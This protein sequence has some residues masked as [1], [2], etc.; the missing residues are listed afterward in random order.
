[1]FKKAICGAALALCSVSA[2]AETTTRWF[3]YTGM[4]EYFGGMSVWYPDVTLKG[5]FSGEDLNGNNI[6]EQD[7][8]T[9]LELEGVNFANPRCGGYD[10]WI[11]RFSFSG[12]NNLDFY[13][14]YSARS[15]HESVHVGSK[16]GYTR[17]FDHEP[18]VHYYGFTLGTTFSITAVPEPSS[19]LMLGA[20][21]V[22]IGA[23]ARRNKRRS[24]ATQ[25]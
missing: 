23:L 8:L 3:T 17:Y 9:H 5:M 18:Y 1:M 21:L 24:A 4:Q 22:G 10:C 15:Y 6:L 11:S 20:G 19:Y 14:G 2:F 25:A 7:E 13:S 16:E 12:G